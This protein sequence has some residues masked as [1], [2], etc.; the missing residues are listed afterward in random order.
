MCT[1]SSSQSA[2]LRFYFLVLVLGLAT[3]SVSAQAMSPEGM[4][5]ESSKAAPLPLSP[6]GT[7]SRWDDIETRLE[8]LLQATEQS[9]MDWDALLTELALVRA[10]VEQLRSDS[11]KSLNLFEDYERRT[12]EQI[13]YI[14][15]RAI[16][17]EELARKAE[18][19]RDGWRTIG[20]V[21]LGLLIIDI[22][23]R[24]LIY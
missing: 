1:V 20:V 7:S 5:S 14:E 23:S 22:L 13:A 17:G 12:S 24:L 9:S 16:A 21:S 6:P 3:A 11:Q 2:W 19:S 18:R 15:A 10:E 4:T 8:T